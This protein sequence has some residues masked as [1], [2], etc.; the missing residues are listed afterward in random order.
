MK[1]VS[2]G[3]V[4]S[5]ALR[6]GANSPVR[7]EDLLGGASFGARCRVALGGVALNVESLLDTGA[8]CEIL[9]HHDLKPFI[10]A[11]L[12]PK[13]LKICRPVPVSGHTNEQTD[14]IEK[15]KPA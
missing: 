14:V 5:L 2:L 8:G 11:R 3:E 9:V 7:V 1:R 12:K 4:S 10:K 6:T 13:I 15:P